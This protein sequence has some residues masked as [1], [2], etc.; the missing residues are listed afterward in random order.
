MKFKAVVFVL[1][2]AILASCGPQKGPKRA[3]LTPAGTTGGYDQ[4]LNAYVH[5]GDSRVEKE[6]EAAA[7]TALE[8]AKPA[9]LTGRLK[10]FEISRFQ[11]GLVEST[12]FGKDRL[13]LKIFFKDREPVEFKAPVKVEGSKI[14]F[15]ALS[16][17]F[18]ISGEIEDQAQRSLGRFTLKDKVRNEEAVIFY[19]A[20]RGKLTVREDREHPVAQGSALDRQIKSL[21]EDTFAWVHNWSVVKGISVY[22]VDIVKVVDKSK[23]RLHAPPPVFR[24]KGESKRTGE[25]T[26]KA[27]TIKSESK[28]QVKLIGNGETTSKRMFEITVPDGD[29]ENSI[30]LDIE[31][32]L[33]DE[34]LPEPEEQPE[35]FGEKDAPIHDGTGFL[36]IDQS[37]ARSARMTKDFDRN[38]NSP[39]VKA[40][41]AK[42]QKKLRPDLTA[43]FKNANPFRGMLETVSATYDVSPAFAYLTVVESAYFT[44]GKYE[45]QKAKTS[46]ALG[47]FQ[48]LDKTATELGLKIGGAADERRFFAPSSCA[49]AKYIRKMVNAFDDS[50]TT[51]AILAY[52]QGPGGAAAAI[53]CSYDG[54]AGNREECAK[55]INSG[56]KGKDYGRFIQLAKR[57]N[58]TYLEME[59]MAAIPKHMRDYVNKKLAVYFVANNMKRY[60][61]S[62]PKNARTSLPTNGTVYPAGPMNDATCQQAIGIDQPST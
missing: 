14:S 28:A 17:D 39:G 53:Y 60:G 38:I 5:N 24:I 32:E 23:P 29:Q 25:N 40:Y 13:T 10:E 7:G 43:F 6:L 45:I 3:R 44:G 46:T 49:A 20:Y 16:D 33:E 9:A 15:T 4:D 36:R 1:L 61:F 35:I 57:Y 58:Y 19:K 11:K 37:K 51:L 50:D 56:F 47:P 30:M 31:A 54:Q 62:I 27:E 8:T 12:R 26:Y 42:F 55:K 2:A 59:R 22:L 41:I 48:I 34:P 52:Y 18:E 21:R